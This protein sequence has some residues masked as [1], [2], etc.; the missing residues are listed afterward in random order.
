MTRF[1]NGDYIKFLEQPKEKVWFFD[2]LFNIKR[3]NKFYICS[4]HINGDNQGEIKYQHELKVDEIYRVR[5]HMLAVE[6]IDSNFLGDVN[7]L[8]FISNHWVNWELLD[9]KETE[10]LIRKEKLKKIG[11]FNIK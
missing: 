8:Y 7:D 2:K 9:K 5:H 11:F 10:K 1:Y 4:Y 6:I 3:N